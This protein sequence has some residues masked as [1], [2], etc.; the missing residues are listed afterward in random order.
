MTK[1]NKPSKPVAN[2]KG[3]QPVK[4]T[5]LPKSNTTL[6]GSHQEILSPQFLEGVLKVLSGHHTLEKF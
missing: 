4:K 1:S 3:D 6:K 5:D 2:Q